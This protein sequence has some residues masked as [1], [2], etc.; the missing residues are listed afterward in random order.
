MVWAM[1]KDDNL[2]PGTFELLKAQE[3][4][5]LEWT[6]RASL[7][8]LLQVKAMAMVDKVDIL[9][10]QL[11]EEC[12]EKSMILGLEESVMEPFQARNLRRERRKPGDRSHRV[13]GT[14]HTLEADRR[15]MSLQTAEYLASTERRGEVVDVGERGRNPE[16]AADPAE[17]PAGVYA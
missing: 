12:W 2:P 5:A 4:M 6:E 14:P 7:C 1:G 3:R 17:G 10:E 9:Y 8:H 11:R 16:A 15:W 13:Q